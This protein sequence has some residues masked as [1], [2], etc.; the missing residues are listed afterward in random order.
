MD[1]ASMN[2]RTTARRRG[3]P[4]TRL[5]D[6]LGMTRTQISNRVH[7]AVAWTLPEAIQAARCL[8]MTLPEFAAYFPDEQSDEEARLKR[9]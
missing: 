6:E 7:G 8:G 1:I 9:R 3:F 4:L 2:F 5:A